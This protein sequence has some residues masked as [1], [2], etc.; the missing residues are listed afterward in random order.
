MY[1]KVYNCSKR[2]GKMCLVRFNVLVA[3][4]QFSI[5]VRLT[6]RKASSLGPFWGE[7]PLPVDSPHKGQ[8]K[9]KV[10]PCHTIIMFPGLSGTGRVVVKYSIKGSSREHLRSKYRVMSQDTCDYFRLSLVDRNDFS[11]LSLK[12]PACER[13]WQW[14]HKRQWQLFFL[15]E[16]MGVLI[17][18]PFNISF[19]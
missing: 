11:V 7:P 1:P 9:W 8:T 17:E 18:F 12:W 5:V 15:N 3:N 16:I 6:T 2:D 10:F 4:A 14:T 19:G 13:G